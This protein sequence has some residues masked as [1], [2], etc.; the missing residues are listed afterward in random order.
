MIMI[1]NDFA[2]AFATV[3]FSPASTNSQGK[4]NKVRK[5]GKFEIADSK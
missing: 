4:Q 5:N 1:P 3:K 2:F